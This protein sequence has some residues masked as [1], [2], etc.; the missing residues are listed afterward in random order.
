M[1]QRPVAESELAPLTGAS[2]DPQLV[3]ALKLVGANR[4]VAVG[5]RDTVL[6]AKDRPGFEW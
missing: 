3:A 1:T 5:T 6:L 2:N 4:Y